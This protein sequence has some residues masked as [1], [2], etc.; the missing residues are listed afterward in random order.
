MQRGLVDD[1][2]ADDGGPVVLVGRGSARRTRPPTGPRGVPRPG[3]RSAACRHDQRT[4]RCSGVRWWG[5]LWSR[6]DRTNGPGERTS[7]DVVIAVVISSAVAQRPSSSA[8]RT[9]SRRLFTPSLLVDALGVGAHGVQ[10]D[11]QL[12]G[13][14]GTAQVAAEQAQHVELAVAQLVDEPGGWRAPSAWRRRVAASTRR[15]W[16]SA[17]SDAGAGAG[18]RVAMVGPSSTKIRT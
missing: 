13:D 12:A 17:A 8:R 4:K 9:A 15:A 14:V 1:R 11:D 2:A 6:A 5:R 18:C 7:H 3:S 16:R 10:R